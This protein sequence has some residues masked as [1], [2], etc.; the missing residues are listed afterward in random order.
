[1]C[2]VRWQVRYAFSPETIIV[3][4][5]DFSYNPVV[6][7]RC[8]LLFLLSSSVLFALPALAVT[9]NITF[10]ADTTLSENWP[11]NNFG[12]MT[13]A[14]AGTTQ[15]FTRNRALFKFDV[16]AS[17]PAGSK[18]KSASLVLEVVGKPQD[19]YNFA[20]FGLHRMLV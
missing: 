12:G 20:D 1:M 13:F 14:N 6:L 16:A 10:V 17:V 9:T 8:V 7:R 15:N 19:G 3:S 2:A 18:I 5:A 4:E 11:S